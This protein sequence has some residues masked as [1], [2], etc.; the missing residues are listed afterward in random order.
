M[1]NISFAVLVWLASALVFGLLF[2]PQAYAQEE[3]TATIKWE[4]PTARTDGSPLERSEL[5]QYIFACREDT[6]G[7][8]FTDRLTIPGDVTQYEAPRADI[9][10]DYGNYLCNL[11]VVDVDG[12]PSAPSN[13]VPV[14]YL[15]EPEAPQGLNFEFTFTVTTTVT[16]S[17]N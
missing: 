7:T 15:A 14:A 17:V 3:R 11:R 6:D 9:F 2:L 16:G 4:P 8:E 13:A 12:L 10:D 1:R 5:E